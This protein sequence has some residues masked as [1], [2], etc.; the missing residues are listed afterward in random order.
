MKLDL[1]LRPT[2]DAARE[3][4]VVRMPDAQEAFRQRRVTHDPE[5]PLPV[6]AQLAPTCRDVA[7][8][9]RMCHGSASRCI[10]HHARAHRCIRFSLRCVEDQTKREA[11]Q[12]SRARLDDLFPSR[13]PKCQ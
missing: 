2:V 8:Q 4:V 3:V 7:A 10:E 1:E 12:L 13:Q 6:R 9:T 5:S 11:V